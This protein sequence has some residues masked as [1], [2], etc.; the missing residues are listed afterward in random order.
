[1]A[2]D[3]FHTDPKFHP[4]VK[5]YCKRLGLKMKEWVQITLAEKMD[6]EPNGPIPIGEIRA[7]FMKM[8]AEIDD[9]K[10]KI[11]ILNRGLKY[12]EKKPAN[13]T[14]ETESARDLFGVHS[15]PSI[16]PRNSKKVPAP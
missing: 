13:V 10:A 9:L 3:I 15:G 8:Q 1:M 14:N 4:I 12:V 7:Q 6:R 5:E 16:S 11:T 2:S